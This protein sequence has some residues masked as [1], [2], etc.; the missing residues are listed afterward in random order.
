MKKYFLNISFLLVL[1]SSFKANAYDPADY[2]ATEKATY[3]ALVK[4][5]DELILAGPPHKSALEAYSGA[6]NEYL[7]SLEIPSPSKSLKQKDILK[8]K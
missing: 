1:I 4:A 8:Q 5:N 7:I 2:A 6:V 3:D